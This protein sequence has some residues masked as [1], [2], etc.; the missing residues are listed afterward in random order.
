MQVDCNDGNICTNDG[1]EP[2]VGCVHSNNSLGCSDGSECT[3]GDK[4]SGGKCTPGQQYPDCEDDNFCTNDYCD[5]AVGCVNEPTNTPCDDGDQCTGGD[6]CSDGECSPGPEQKD[7]DDADDCTTDTCDPVF[8]CLNLFNELPC[9]DGDECTEKDVCTFGQCGGQTLICNDDSLCTDD[10]CDSNKPGGCVFTPNN[11]SCDDGD[12]CTLGDTCSAGE[13]LSG[14]GLLECDDENPCTDDVCTAMVGCEYPPIVAL[15]DDEELCT[16]GDYCSG[17]ECVSGQNVCECETDSDCDEQEDGNFC[18]GTLECITSYPDPAAWDCVV[19]PLTIVVCD[20]ADDTECKVAQ[21]Q[22]GTGNCIM[23]PVNNNGNCDDGSVCTTVDACSAGT[24]VGIED[25]DCNDNEECTDEYCHPTQG[26]QTSHVAEGT[27][28]G[29]AGYACQGGECLPCTPACVNKDCGPDGCGGSCGSC[30]DDE[31]CTQAGLCVPECQDCA[32]WQE[33]TDGMCEDP[34]SMGSCP[35]GGIMLSD[36]CEDTPYDGCCS[37]D[38]GRELYYCGFW[39]ECPGNYI[40]CLCHVECSSWAVCS[41]DSWDDKFACSLPPA[42]QDPQ[43]NLYCDWWP[44]EPD[45]AGKDCGSDGC[46]GSCGTCPDNFECDAGV[47]DYQG[48]AGCYGYDDP[49]HEDCFGITYDGC[50]D[51]SGRMLYCVNGDLYCVDCPAVDPWCG[52]DS[53]NQWFDCGTSGGN[54]PTGSKACPVC[55]P[56]CPAGYSCVAGDCVN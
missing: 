54:G 33:C 42:D 13:C 47:C 23:V 40:Y 38:E 56:S 50:C 39:S 44:C 29:Q 24:C 3:L 20:D 51:P 45:C 43:G 55:V 46:G 5:P 32:P 7:C 1:C 4:C 26:C 34:P 52:W 14:M 30:E 19:D 31:M 22:A 48:L 18:N 12:P 35:G 53:G 16:V 25:L 15:C 6:L 28:C 9:N 21:C 2:V 8:G 27:P 41:Y 49:A 36:D 37:G 17:G 10:S 11:D